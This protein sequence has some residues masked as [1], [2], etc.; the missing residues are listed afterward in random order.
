MSPISFDLHLAIKVIRQR[1]Q[2]HYLVHLL[3]VSMSCKFHGTLYVYGFGKIIQYLSEI[4]V[5]RG[6]ETAEP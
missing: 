2:L 1:R 5:T 6:R 4:S 3:D